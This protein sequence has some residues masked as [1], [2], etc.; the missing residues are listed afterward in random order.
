MKKI[1][2]FLVFLSTLQNFGQVEVV[3][4]FPIYGSKMVNSKIVFARNSPEFGNELWVSNGTAGNAQL[5]KDIIVGSQSSN[6]EI[7]TVIGNKVYFVANQHQIWQTDG[8]T[9]GTFLMVNNNQITNPSEFVEVGQFIFFKSGGNL[10]KMLGTPNSESL[11]NNTPDIFFTAISG[12]TKLNDSEVLFNARRNS[13]NTWGIWRSNG[14]VTQ[15]VIDINT[16]TG[17]LEIAQ[18]RLPKNIDGTI[19]FD[20]YSIETGGELWKTNGSATGTE[21]ILDIYGVNDNPFTSF[22]GPRYFTAVNEMIFFSAR[23]ALN[24]IELWKTNG[25][26]AGTIMVKSITAGNNTNGGPFSLTA[27][28]DLLYFVQS[29]TENSGSA[30]IWKSDGSET[31]TTKVTNLTG[32]YLNVYDLFE[33]NGNIYFNYFQPSTGQELWK[34]NAVND[35]YSLIADIAPGTISSE[36]SGFFE[37]KGYI[38]FNATDNGFLGGTKFYRIADQSLSTVDVNKKVTSIYPNPTHGIITIQIEDSNN[39]EVELYDV[40]GKK[41]AHFSNQKKIDISNLTNGMYVLKIVDSENN[42]ISNN[43]II[44]K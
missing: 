21:L 35:T 33:S 3:E 34:L 31:G 5:L 11:V 13:N 8:T 16:G 14:V 40:Y 37:M 28:D 27:V 32:S 17:S 25:T 9:N 19:Y 10:W 1:T 44:K 36:P 15:F 43:K 7:G 12:I 41:I 18:M 38:Y 29:D 6:P 39:F 30:Q 26:T 24:G 23:N 42:L 2:S 20:G 22:S 4:N